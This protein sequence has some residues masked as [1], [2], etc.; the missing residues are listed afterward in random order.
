MGTD[1]EEA[2]MDLGARPF[3]V[4]WVITLPLIL[5]ALVAGWLLS[6]TLSLDDLVIAS[7][8]TGPGST[9]LPMVIFSKVRLGLNPMIN[10]VATLI[11]ATVAI[12]I[13]I[14]GITMYRQARRER[15]S[16]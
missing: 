4:F 11:I 5:P 15:A 9:T 16:S 14:A 1:L 7:F 10:A 3:K 6:F 8:V 13:I 2:A 12:G